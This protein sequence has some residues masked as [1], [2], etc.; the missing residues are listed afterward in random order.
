MSKVLTSLHTNYL[1]NLDNTADR[2]ISQRSERIDC[3]CNPEETGTKIFAYIKFLCDNIRMN[4]VIT[5]SP[6]S[7]VAVISLYQSVTKLIFLDA[8]WFE[9]G[10][11]DDQ[12]YIPLYVLV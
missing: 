1:A 11:G 2:V 3:Y 12:R 4:R 7:V 6:N 8:L 10:T 9:T 5:V